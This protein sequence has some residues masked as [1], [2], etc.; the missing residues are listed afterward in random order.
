MFNR[1]FL[2]KDKQPVVAISNVDFNEAKFS[3]FVKKLRLG[4]SYYVFENVCVSSVGRDGIYILDDYNDK[5]S[6]INQTQPA[7]Y[8]LFRDGVM[9]QQIDFRWKTMRAHLVN[10][11]TVAHKTWIKG[12]G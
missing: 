12:R 7:W 2:E 11:S 4:T 1:R 5:G 10:H 6:L 9:E 8:K 3:R